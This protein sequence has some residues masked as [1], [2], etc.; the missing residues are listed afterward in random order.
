MS[1]ASTPYPVRHADAD[2][3]SPGN[4]LEMPNSRPRFQNVVLKGGQ[5]YAKGSVLGQITATGKYTLALAAA[6]DGSQNP[7]AV[8][9]VD[10]DA[11]QNTNA[12]V[13]FDVMATGAVLNPAALVLGTGITSAAA[14]AA[15]MG[16]G[17]T[18]RTPGFS[19][20]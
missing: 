4:D 8:L 9:S 13:N 11:T 5:V 15:L 3:W 16:R 1:Y 7:I 20:V 14:Q 6:G 10:I 17:F 19:P 2:S 12:D 18:F